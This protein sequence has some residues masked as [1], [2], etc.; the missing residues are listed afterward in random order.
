MDKH[1]PDGIE[2]VFMQGMHGRGA[3]GLVIVARFPSTHPLG[4]KVD[5]PPGVIEGVSS[6][7]LHPVQSL[8]RGLRRSLECRREICKRFWCS[9]H[10]NWRTHL[11][12]SFEEESP[13][14]GGPQRLNTTSNEPWHWEAT[15]VRA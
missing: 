8:S 15:S 1:L 9:N 6:M 10:V 13:C 2:R 3:D 5:I 14:I 11:M 12:A 7:G 4:S